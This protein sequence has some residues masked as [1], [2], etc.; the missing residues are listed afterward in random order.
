[1]KIS[2]KYLNRSFWNNKNI[3]IT[4]ING[5]IGGNLC[6]YL[7]N[8]GCSI[9]GV[10]NRKNKSKFLHFEKIHS[11][12]KISYTDISNYK[13]I[14]SLIKNNDID[15]CFHLAAQVDVNIAKNK[16][17]ETFETN[18]K[19]TYNLLESL[20]LHSKVKSIIVASSDKAYGEYNI[21][22]LPY[23]ETYD[24]RPKYPYDVS[25]AAADMITKSYST[26]LFNMPLITTRFSN[27]Y[28][29]GQLNF[30]AL[31]PDCILANLGYKNFLPRGNGNNNRDFLFVEDVSDL[32]MCLA[33]H[34]YKDKSLTGEI[35]NAGTGKPYKVK[36]VIKSIC[37]LNNN[38]E[39]YKKILD[40]FKGK[41]TIGEITHQYMS[42]NKLNKYFK[43]MPNYTLDNGLKKTFLWY[44]EFL[45]KYNYKD[46]I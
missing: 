4:G 6:K 33:Y 26:E 18:I 15:I 14:E 41:K 37:S 36:T 24:L 44:K 43:W 2:K 34:L 11:K 27:I 20:R 30:S 19:G 42:Y 46:F 22:D 23:K 35:F 45:T 21:K 16:P 9:I 38:H 29:P 1:M 12:I 25:K 39:L 10:T 40:K 32:Y 28:G 3:L 17:F 31:I 8:H 13:S 7:L 5:F